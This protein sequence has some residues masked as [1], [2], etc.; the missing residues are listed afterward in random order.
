MSVT[1][2]ARPSSTAPAPRTGPEGWSDSRAVVSSPRPRRNVYSARSRGSDSS[3]SN[4]VSCV[5][6]S[7]RRDRL[8]RYWRYA[9]R[10]HR[11]KLARRACSARRAARSSPNASRCR[12]SN[13]GSASQDASATSSSASH[14]GLATCR[15]DSGSNNSNGASAAACRRRNARRRWSARTSFPAAR[16]ASFHASRA[17][18]ACLRRSSG[19][20]RNNGAAS[21]AVWVPR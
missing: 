13:S 20:T 12:R 16:A 3:T 8:R 19:E 21:T 15:P 6:K 14:C 4:K 2:G 9:T 5:R 10:H 7:P 18:R 11:R 1:A 17:W